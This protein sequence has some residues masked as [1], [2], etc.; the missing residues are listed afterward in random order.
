MK[1]SIIIIWGIL[2]L[3]KQGT[4]IGAQELVETVMATSFFIKQGD[5]TKERK[6]DIIVNP[7]NFNLEFGGE[8]SAALKKADPG[9]AGALIRDKEAIMKAQNFGEGKKRA[10]I[11]HIFALRKEQKIKSIISA[12]GPTGTSPNWKFL[13]K[14]TYE[15]ILSLAHEH[16]IESII[17]PPI[18]TETNSRGSDG[19]VVI[20]PTEAAKIAVSATED[21]VKKHPK[22]SLRKIIFISSLNDGPVH[23]L[24]HK[25]AFQGHLA[26][27]TEEKKLVDSEAEYISKLQKPMRFEKFQKFIKSQKDRVINFIKQRKTPLA[28]GTLATLASLYLLK[29]Y[30]FLFFPTKKD[31]FSKFYSIVK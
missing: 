17:F 10:I 28:L 2:F 8:I 20:T 29:K 16:S 30:Q 7:T 22:T 14:K 3:I 31:I 13:L 6:I 25:R 11:S 1:K 24:A 19:T 18:S 21:Y 5:I 4:I 15:D 9:W 27:T 26:S 12:V 23:S